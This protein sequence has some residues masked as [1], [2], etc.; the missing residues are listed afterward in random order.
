[1]LTVS[2]LLRVEPVG[3]PNWSTFKSLKHKTTECFLCVYY[4]IDTTTLKLL[5]AQVTAVR[6]K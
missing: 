6:P 2:T 1:M 3:G 4:D 5:S